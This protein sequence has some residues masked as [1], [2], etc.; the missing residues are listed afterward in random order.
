MPTMTI[1]FQDDA[2]RLALEQSLP[3]FP[4]YGKPR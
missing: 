1:E 4:S 2:E 3:Y